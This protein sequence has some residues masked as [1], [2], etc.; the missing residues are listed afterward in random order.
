[1]TDDVD[2]YRTAIKRA[3]KGLSF[4]WLKLKSGTKR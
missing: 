2:A 3:A 4:A 1:M